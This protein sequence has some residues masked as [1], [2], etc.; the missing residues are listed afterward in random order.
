MT[1]CQGSDS[2]ST[3]FLLCKGDEKTEC[4]NNLVVRGKDERQI[5]RSRVR[6]RT[7]IKVTGKAK[8][9]NEGHM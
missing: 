3:Q 7:D 2:S 1:Q 9:I 6:P 8:D 4:K 5:S